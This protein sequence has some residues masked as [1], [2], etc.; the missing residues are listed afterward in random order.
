MTKQDSFAQPDFLNEGK[1]L[2]LL[3]DFSE[4]LLHREKTGCINEVDVC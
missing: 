3:Q 1:V 2:N 4:L